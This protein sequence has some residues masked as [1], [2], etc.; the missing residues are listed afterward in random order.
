MCSRDV[1][2]HT[3]YSLISVHAETF[4][5]TFNP[6]I[7]QHKEISLISAVCHLHNKEMRQ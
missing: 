6:E 5:H 7:S 3:A 2:P 1:K 4:D